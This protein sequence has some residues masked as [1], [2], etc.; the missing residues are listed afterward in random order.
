MINN[1]EMSEICIACVLCG[2]MCFASVFCVVN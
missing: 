2:E 1:K